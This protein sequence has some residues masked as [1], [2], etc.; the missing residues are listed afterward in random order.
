MSSHD[1]IIIGGGIQGAMLALECARRGRRPL[2]VERATCGEGATASSFGIIHG[3]LRYLQ[4]FDFRRWRRSRREQKWFAREFGDAVTQLRCVMPLYRGALRSRLLFRAAFAAQAL[5]S[6][7]FELGEAGTVTGLLTSAQTR[8][9]YPIPEEGLIGGAYWSE[10]VVHDATALVRAILRRVEGLGGTVIEQREASELLTRGGAVVGLAVRDRASNAVVHYFSDTVFVCAGFASQRIAAHFDRPLPLLSARVL[11]F[12]LLLDAPAPAG[13]A[14]AVSAVPGRGRS[15]FLREH[16]GRLLA[17][18]AYAPAT[19]PSGSTAVPR[20]E[21]ERFLGEIVRAA[22][23]LASA[24][25][26]R[27]WSG[28]LPDRD[29]TGLRLRARDVAWDHGRHGGPCGLHTV[30]PTKLTTAHALACDV[31]DRIWPHT[32]PPVANAARAWRPSPSLGKG[33]AE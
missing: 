28:L 6:R 33:S 21:V 18:T 23:T 25:V 5:A 7:L 31:L 9:L 12:N 16:D 13:V 19:D 8:A 2:L 10:L 24:R 14:L 29:E 3:G 26:L 1:A 4:A 30:T 20:E 27:V 32:H 15:L 22:P 11:A 17:G